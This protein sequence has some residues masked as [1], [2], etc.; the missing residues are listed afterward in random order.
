VVVVLSG[1]D[2]ELGS[3]VV[4]VGYGEEKIVVGRAV[5][6]VGSGERVVTS[7]GCSSVLGCGRVRFGWKSCCFTICSRG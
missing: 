7:F 6:V 2:E 1:T 4:V 3:L 5:V